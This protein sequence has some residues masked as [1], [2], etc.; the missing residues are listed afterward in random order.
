MCLPCFW[1]DS[2]VLSQLPRPPTVITEEPSVQNSDLQ[3]PFF[4]LGFMRNV[5]RIVTLLKI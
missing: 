4:T 1:M 2:F 3:S 5:S